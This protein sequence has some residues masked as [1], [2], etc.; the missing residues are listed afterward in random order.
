MIRSAVNKIEEVEELIRETFIEQLPIHIKNQL[1]TWR[2]KKESI[3]IL[4]KEVEQI[5]IIFEHD[6][7]LLAST[8][9]Y[10]DK[11]DGIANS[12]TKR[13]SEISPWSSFVTYVSSTPLTE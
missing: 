10:L 2:I 7:A 4:I 1:T 9:Q 3:D 8:Y 11:Y 5:N 12:N 6:Q 13:Q